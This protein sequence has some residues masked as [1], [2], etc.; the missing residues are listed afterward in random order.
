MSAVVQ[1]GSAQRK[2]APRKQPARSEIT[3]IAGKLSKRVAQALA[4]LPADQQRK[5]LRKEDALA[6]ALQ[7]AV[8]E[9]LATPDTKPKAVKT[10]RPLEKKVGSGLGAPLS[11]EKSQ[12]AL[13][14]YAT[15][16]RIEEWAGDVAGSTEIER[17]L[18]ISRSTLYSWTTRSAVISLR[19]G[20]RNHV[21]PLAQFIDGRPIEGIE[22]VISAASNHRAAW[23]WLL[24]DKP[25]IGGAP[26]DLL[27]AGKVGEVVRA[28][29]RDFG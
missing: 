16:Q 8:I 17:E 20:R 19:K 10:S 18:G 27:K 2:T 23:Q 1:R 24:Q 7:S 12:E 28:A 9:F 6:N 22:E 5:L 25:S 26:L 14:K 13:L 15:A 11:A 29:E 4:Q 3:A 21:Y